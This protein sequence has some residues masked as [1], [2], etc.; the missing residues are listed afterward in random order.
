MNVFTRLVERFETQER[1]A[2]A[3]GVSQ[4]NVSKWV[5]GKQGMAP[6]IAR[7]VERLTN[8]DFTAAELC[9]RVFGDEPYAA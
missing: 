5:R 1:L 2:E 4:P 6:E 3:I 9:P 7:R 8:G